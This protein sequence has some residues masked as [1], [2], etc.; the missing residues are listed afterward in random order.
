MPL[1]TVSISCLYLA[2][3]AYLFSLVS[4]VLCKERM[5]DVCFFGGFLFHTISQVSRGWFIGIFTPIA[6][7][8]V[9]FFLPWCLA[10][11]TLCLRFFTKE[12]QLGCSAIIPVLF[13]L[14]IALQC[15][16]GVFPPSPQGQT[17]FSP[18]FFLFEVPAQAFFVLGAWF[19]FQYL[20]REAEAGFFD[21][22]IIW[23]FIFY[24]I[25]QVAGAIWCYLGWASLFNWSERHLQS[26]AI[27]C[28]YAAYIHLRF[29]YVR[30]MK[31]KAWFSIAGFA[32]LLLVII[33]GH[34]NE[35]NMPRLGL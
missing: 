28:F 15:P 23:G 7:V 19:A 26:A 11:L 32:L 10:F 2:A 35:M 8:E 17:I 25:A 5:R 21:S 29:L 22:L 24:S 27:W 9:N 20:R 16:K 13:F 31:R 33:L 12:K 3:G 4:F 14:L 30:D 18:L 6:M 34:L 1:S